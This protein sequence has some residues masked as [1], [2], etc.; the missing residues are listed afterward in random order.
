MPKTKVFIFMSL[1]VL[2]TACGGDKKD[3]KKGMTISG[4]L[5][6]NCQP[7]PS[8][9]TPMTDP[10]ISNILS[11]VSQQCMMQRQSNQQFAQK[12]QFGAATFSA[13]YQVVS[14]VANQY[15]NPYGT[16]NPYQQQYGMQ[17]Y[18]V[19]GISIPL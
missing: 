10:G 9:G 17:Q 8:Q 16:Q 2:A 14:P 4:M 3:S 13:S 6:N 18:Q 7:I 5:S 12:L 15:S 19:T 1:L 11:Q